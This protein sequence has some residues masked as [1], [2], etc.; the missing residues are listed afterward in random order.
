MQDFFYDYAQQYG[1]SWPTP[2]YNLV[3]TIIKEA[4]LK[5]SYAEKQKIKSF[6]WNFNF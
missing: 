1:L 3:N 6:F 4:V 5:K 2:V